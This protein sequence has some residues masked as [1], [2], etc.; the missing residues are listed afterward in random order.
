MQELAGAVG[1]PWS[2]KLR[3][4][5][6]PGY[7]CSKLL[8]ELIC[9]SRQAAV[10]KCVFAGNPTAGGARLDMNIARVNTPPI[11]KGNL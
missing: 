3:V 1:A 7:C 11:R 5:A 9:L 10:E 4:T 6:R 8:T 2:A